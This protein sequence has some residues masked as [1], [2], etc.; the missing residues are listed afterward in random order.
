V[1]RES[2]ASLRGAALL[3]RVRALCLSLPETAEVSSW[4]HPNFRAGKR[5]FL[6]FEQV[7]GV[8]AI[9][10]H[11]HPFEV[12]E[13]ERLAGFTRT[14]YG[15]GRWVS[16]RIRPRPA[17]NTVKDLVLRSYRQV[18]IKRMR[19]KL[20]QSGVASGSRRFRP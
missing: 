4:G 16:L 8:D 18:A 19:L 9:A 12:E 2:P 7:D 3:A 10:F 20:E 17:W 15:Q 5:T 13:L 11:L 1:P 6:S 14:P